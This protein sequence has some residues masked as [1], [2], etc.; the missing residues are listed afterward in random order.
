MA[1]YFVSAAS[2]SDVNSGLSEALAWA[3]VDKGMNTVAAGDKVWVKGDGDYAE[4]AGI[5]TIGTA[6]API[7]FEGYTTTT[8]DG[9]RATIT[10]SGSRTNC[11][12]QV[13]GGSSLYY[14]FK[15]FRFTNTTANAVS[16]TG[17]QLTFKN[18]KFDTAANNGLACGMCVCEACEFSSNTLTGCLAS[19]GGI[20]IGCKFYSNTTD[21]LKSQGNSTVIFGCTFFSN[22]G[23][24]IN[25]GVGG[26]VSCIANCT[27]DGDGKDSDSGISINSVFAMVAVVNTV[28]YDC[29]TG[30]TVP[31]GDMGER[32]VSRNN[33]VNANTADYSNAATF[34]GEITSAPQFTDEVAGADYTPAVGSPLINAGLNG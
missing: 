17:G 33:L 18:C 16:A 21:G 27:V 2:G 28:L 8:G 14:V 34:T 25:V 32:V 30:F 4:L 6:T 5:D 9:G 1:I 10:G 20:F 19:D 13:V 15:N 31:G 7:I 24:N 29:T 3:T 22:A 23:I 12:L 26:E 11:I